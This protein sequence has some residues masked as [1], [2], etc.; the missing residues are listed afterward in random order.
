MICGY[1][2]TADNVCGAAIAED[3]SSPTGFT[4]TEGHGWLHFASPESYGMSEEE[5]DRVFKP[6]AVCGKKEPE[7]EAHVL[8]RGH[9]FRAVV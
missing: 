5:S 2:P 1:T 7:N 9:A 8:I 3:L 4:H 6:C